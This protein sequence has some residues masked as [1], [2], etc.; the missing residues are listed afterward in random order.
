MYSGSGLAYRHRVDKRGSGEPIANL[1]ALP[2]VT[3]CEREVAQDDY[4]LRGIPAI[5]WRDD[6]P[7]LFEQLQL[8]ENTDYFIDIT[9]PISKIE[10]ERRTAL[11]PARPFS[12]RLRGVFASDP[13]SRWKEPDAAISLFLA[14]CDAATMPA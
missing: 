5:C 14:S 11:R 2:F 4:A 9:L 12:E 1:P 3:L 7:V 6:G 8:R 13:P 10:A